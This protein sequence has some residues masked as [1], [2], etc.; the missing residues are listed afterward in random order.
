MPRR[1]LICLGLLLCFSLASLQADNWP[2][3]RGPSRDG[4]STATGLPTE[5]NETNNIVWKLAL[6][7]MSGATPAVWGDK[8]FLTSGDGNDVVLMCISADGKPLWKRP[9][10]Q[11]DRVFREDEGNQ[12]SPS[13]S[14]DGTRVYAFTG[15]GDFACFDFEGNQKWKFNLQERY[16]QFRIQHGMHVTPLLH[17]DRLYLSLLHSG[18]WQVLAFDKSDGKE[19]WKVKRETDAKRECE[20]AYASPILGNDGKEE[21]LIVHGCDYTTG[22]RLKDGSEIWRLTDLN[23]KS[24]YHNTLRFVAT[25]VASGGLIIVPTAKKK[26]VVAMKPD[27]TGMIKAGNPAELWRKP[28]GTPDVSSPLVYDGLVYLCN[29]N[30]FLTCL[31]TKSGQQHYHERLH[32]A[33]YRASPV[34]ADGKIY[35]VARDGTVCVVKAGTKFELLAKNKL[36]DELAASPVIAHG[37]IYLRG[38]TTLY[39]IGTERK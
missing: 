35:C 31:D 13:P 6:P 1:H 7:G 3:W 25:P 16:G 26:L 39:A 36:P 37:R 17:G 5:W 19:V 29:E 34:Y 4:V 14:T 33:R 20:Q 10:S 8:L 9:L 18:G 12:A 28:S 32:I 23:P 27:A 11:G 21:Y 38:F 2:H 24:T 22:H 15:R 30:G